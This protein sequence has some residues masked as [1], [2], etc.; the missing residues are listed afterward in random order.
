MRRSGVDR[1]SRIAIGRLTR[2]GRVVLWRSGTDAGLI[3]I[4]CLVRSVSVMLR[5]RR[6][7]GGLLGIAGGA[8]SV[9]VVLR[10]KRRG[11]GLLRILR[12]GPSFG[13]SLQRSAGGSRSTVRTKARS[14]G[15]RRTT[16]STVA[17][18]GS[19]RFLAVACGRRNRIGL[20]AQEDPVLARRLRTH[21][22]GKRDEHLAAQQK[23]GHGIQD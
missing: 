20:G 15:Q 21:R 11:G 10:S 7:G 5:S 17:G 14:V 12:R 1:A 3:R 6:H 4:R 19:G 8:R 23:L 9:S 2:R 13:A 16:R 22:L 18:H